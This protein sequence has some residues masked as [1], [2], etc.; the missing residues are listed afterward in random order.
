L[1]T[2]RLINEEFTHFHLPSLSG[3]VRAVSPLF[4]SSV[5]E[6]HLLPWIQ[7]PPASH[8]ALCSAAL[9]LPT[10]LLTLIEAVG[11]GVPAKTREH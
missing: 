6:L 4:Y 9:P 2:Y 1:N 7:T 3:P 5:Q 8:S 10:S 11:P